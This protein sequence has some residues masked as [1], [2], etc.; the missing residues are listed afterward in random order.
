MGNTHSKDLV[1]VHF[2][3]IETNKQ[4]TLVLVEFFFKNLY[5]DFYSDDVKNI[6]HTFSLGRR[7]PV[8]ACPTCQREIAASIVG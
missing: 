7:G 8:V 6:L 2:M 3:K 1:R 4:C 5:R